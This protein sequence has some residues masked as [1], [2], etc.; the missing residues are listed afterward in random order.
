MFLVM[1]RISIQELKRRLSRVLAEAEGG[2]TLLVTRHGR[3]VARIMPAELEHVHVGS[4]AGRSCIEPLLNGPTRGR[5][6]TFW[7]R[8]GAAA[9]P[10]DPDGGAVRQ[11]DAG[12]RPPRSW[13]S[14]SEAQRREVGW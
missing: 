8:T 7:R 2:A 11:L 14:P 12:P 6:S 13:V 4:R 3:A 9:G 10:A 5:Y 1:K